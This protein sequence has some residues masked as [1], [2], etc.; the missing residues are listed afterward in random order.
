LDLW[1][2]LSFYAQRWCATVY[3]FTQPYFPLPTSDFRLRV[4][5]R[6]DAAQQRL[7]AHA[8]GWICR[9]LVSP[10]FYTFPRLHLYT[11]LFPT[12]HLRLPTSSYF[13]L[14]VGSRSDAAQQRLAAIAKKRSRRMF[15]P[16]YFYTFPRLHLY[17]AL[18]PTSHLRLPTSSYF[19]LRVGSRSDAAQQPATSSAL[20]ATS[21]ALAARSACERMDMPDVGLAL[22]LHFSPFTPLHSPISHFPLPTSDFELLPTS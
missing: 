2:I 19:R 1:R 14:R 22:L 12:S 9:M 4:G 10:Y 15:F 3:T 17:T 13:R 18:F 6:S 20:P 11:A 5:S 21:S 16:P 8:R 7:A